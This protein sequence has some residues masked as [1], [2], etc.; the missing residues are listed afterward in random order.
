MPYNDAGKFLLDYYSFTP[1]EQWILEKTI[2]R[3]RFPRPPAALG[4]GGIYRADPPSLEKNPTPRGFSP[5]S[6][7]AR[8]QLLRRDW[9]RGVEVPLT[10]RCRV[11]PRALAAGFFIPR[12]KI[13]GYRASS[14]TGDGVKMKRHRVYDP[15]MAG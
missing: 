12:R 7:W 14:Q 11:L 6:P 1:N 9:S 8:A 13:V 5:F 4:V 2:R 3:F 10:T 15:S